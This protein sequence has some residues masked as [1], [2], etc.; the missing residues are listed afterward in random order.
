MDQMLNEET[1]LYGSSLPEKNWINFVQD[2]VSFGQSR[3]VLH[4]ATPLSW[5]PQDRFMVP[6]NHSLSFTNYSVFLMVLKGF[7][8]LGHFTVFRRHFNN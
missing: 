2:I 5:R 3:A 6:S 7:T 1:Y 8:A 4:I